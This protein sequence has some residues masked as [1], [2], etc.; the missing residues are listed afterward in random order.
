MNFF[1]RDVED[2]DRSK[3]LEEEIEEARRQRLA[4]R[5]GT[6]PFLFYLSLIL[7]C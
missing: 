1:I 2:Y 5:A 3:K 6:H 4:R 7:F